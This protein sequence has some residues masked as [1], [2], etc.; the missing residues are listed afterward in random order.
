MKAILQSVSR[1]F[2]LT[3]KFLPRGLREPVSLAYLLAR[4]TDT[5]ADTAAI[6]AAI[7]LTILRD[8]ARV[9]AGEQDFSAVE[10]SLR[11][12]AI[13]Q[14]DPA[15][16]TLI[17]NLGGCIDWL[18]QLEPANQADIRAVLKI[19]VRGQELDLERFGDP[20]TAAPL[21]TAAELDEYTYLVAGCV[22]E[23]W[24]RLGFRH[25]PNFATRPPEEMTELG[26]RYG[27]GLQL[28]NVLRDRAADAAAGRGYLPVEELAQSS[29]EEV[30]ARWI[31][32]AEEK[33]GRGIT[34]SSSLTNWR[35][36]YATVLPALLGAR[37]I[38]L[39][40]AAGPAAPKIKVPRKEV[41]HLLAAAL[42]AVLSPRALQNLFQRLIAPS[43]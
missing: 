40:R 8:F 6:P 21:R 43:R 39:L 25:L 12:F 2:Y 27:E 9:I 22:G 31:G 4:A 37:T 19:I 1:S 10:E 14:T 5:L 36:R 28:I 3:I 7:R 41:R 15:E 18:A 13:Q 32:R 26:I 23:F 35:I 17:E 33:V 30:F 16:R 29:V 34:Y 42:P 20:A 38:A 11:D 24:T